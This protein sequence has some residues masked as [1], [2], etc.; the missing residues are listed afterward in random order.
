MKAEDQLLQARNDVIK[1]DIGRQPVGKKKGD[2]RG[3][4]FSKSH[5]GRHFI[6]FIPL[7]LHQIY[8]EHPICERDYSGLDK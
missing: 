8:I 3:W 6:C 5:W 4:T 1:V 7:F 2:S